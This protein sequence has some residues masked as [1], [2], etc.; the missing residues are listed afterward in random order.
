MNIVYADVDGNV[1]YAMSGRLPVRA[2][3]DGTLPAD[4]NA[5]PAWNGIDRAGRAAAR[6]SI[7]RRD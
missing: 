4:G 6:C 7:R 1:G 2:S 5:A 3:G